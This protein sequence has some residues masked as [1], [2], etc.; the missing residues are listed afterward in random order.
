M[1]FKTRE[2]GTSEDLIFSQG[3]VR[4][5]ALLPKRVTLATALQSLT[6]LPNTVYCAFRLT[7]QVL[8]LPALDILA[9]NGVIFNSF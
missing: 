6:F 8:E 7:K 9:G 3:A 5:A 4:P 1:K 2:T